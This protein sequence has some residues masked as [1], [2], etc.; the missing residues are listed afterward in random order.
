MKD[1]KLPPLRKPVITELPE[2][3]AAFM[4]TSDSKKRIRKKNTVSRRVRY[5]FSSLFRYDDELR[6]QIA[7]LLGYTNLNLSTLV[8]MLIRKEFLRLKRKNAI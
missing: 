1:V 8:R 4:L 3:D 5:K 7:V 2:N 6:G